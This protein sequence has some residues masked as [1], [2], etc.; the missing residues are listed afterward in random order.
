MGCS[1]SIQSEVANN[2]NNITEWIYTNNNLDDIGYSFNTGMWI[3]MYP[4][5]EMKERWTEATHLYNSQ[6]ADFYLIGVKC[7]N[8][9][10]YSN[11]QEGQIMFYF[12]NSDEEYLITKKG[13]ELIKLLNYTYT[14]YIVY[15]TSNQNKYKYILKNVRYVPICDICKKVLPVI[16]SKLNN[17]CIVC[18]TNRSKSLDRIIDK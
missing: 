16:N 5:S 18:K 6:P 12:C 1:T 3:F 4:M 11:L 8:F 13:R 17:V 15:Q 14:S 10:Y 9:N 7:L 2:N